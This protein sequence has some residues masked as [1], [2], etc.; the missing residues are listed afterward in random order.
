MTEIRIRF[1]PLLPADIRFAVEFCDEAWLGGEF[2]ERVLDL[3]KERGVAVAL[4]DSKLRICEVRF[5]TV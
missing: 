2:G 3:F 4:V 1:I 5:G